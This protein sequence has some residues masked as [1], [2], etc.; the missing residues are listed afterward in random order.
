MVITYSEIKWDPHGVEMA[1]N[2]P[3]VDND[4]RVD[5]MTEGDKI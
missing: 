4:I 2:R 3:Y 5:A 1:T